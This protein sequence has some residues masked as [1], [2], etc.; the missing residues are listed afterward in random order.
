MPFTLGSAKTG[1]QSPVVV[2]AAAAVV[3]AVAGGEG[4]EEGCNHARQE[5]GI[6]PVDLRPQTL[7]LLGAGLS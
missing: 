4:G 5:F 3:A 7:A 2:A 6:Y 1:P